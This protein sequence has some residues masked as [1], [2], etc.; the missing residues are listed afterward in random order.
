MSAIAGFVRFDGQNAELEDGEAMMVAMRGYVADDERMKLAGPAFLGCRIRWI[1]PESVSERMPGGDPEGRLLIAAD[2][3]LD[4]RT[5]LFERLQVDRDRRAGMTDSELILL[6][7]RKWG[8]EAPEHLL[9]DFAFMIWD[10]ERRLLFGARDPFGNRSLYYHRSDSRLAF[11]TAIAP[12]L[13]LRGTPNRLNEQWLAEFMAIPEMFESTDPEATPYLGIRQVPPGHAIAVSEGRVSVAGYGTLEPGEPLRLKSDGEYEEAFRA[14][15]EKAVACRLRT[16]RKVAVTLS[17][18]LDSGTVASFAAKA[19]RKEGKTLQAYSSVPT[20]EF[21]DW[22][23]RGTVADERPF[24]RATARH[25]GNI[26]ETYLDFKGISPLSEV[27]EWLDLLETPYKFF[28]NSYW[29]KGIHERASGQGAGILLTGARG[30]FTVSWGPALDYYALLMRQMR[31]LSLSRELRQYGENKGI[32][33]KRLLAAVGKLAFPALTRRSRAKP[34]PRPE[35]PAMLI[36]PGFAARTGVFDLLKRRESERTAADP[37][38]LRLAKLASPAA[39]NKN[40]ATASKLSL[41]YGTWERDPTCDLRVVR[42]CLAVPFEQYVRGGKDRALIR[43]ATANVLPDEVRLNQRS[44]GIQGADWVHRSAPMW[45]MLTEEVAR[46]CS[47]PDVA[48]Y[49]NVGRIREAAAGIGREPRPELAF[50]PEMR[51]LMR[52]LI[53]YRFIKRFA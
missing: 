46:L 32:G 53:L 8:R 28:E 23:P 52:S 12:L 37:A 9:G 10:A 49:L 11:C 3:I 35:L 39:A 6:A 17:G 31:W 41:R 40:G 18:G 27:D 14:V 4:N 33:R 38:A 5:E 48:G 24:I 43:R 29:L 20:P 36:H 13:V 15:F 25:A 45:P 51:L 30:N 50:H 21:D 47:D 42:F 1:T 2:A 22:T 7:Y 16:F 19:L 44:R 34:E 26:S